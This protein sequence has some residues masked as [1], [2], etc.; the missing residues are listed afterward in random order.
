MKKLTVDYGNGITW[1]FDNFPEKY[2]TQW[3]NNS[4]WVQ[5]ELPSQTLWV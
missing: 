1:H 3:V 4:F 2:D 5:V